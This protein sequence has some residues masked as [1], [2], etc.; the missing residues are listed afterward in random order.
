M[1]ICLDVP[2]K[3]TTVDVLLAPSYVGLL[4]YDLPRSLGKVLGNV[5]LLL[6]HSGA[7]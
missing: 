5:F 2:G 4:G 1:H 6:E 3:D 7:R